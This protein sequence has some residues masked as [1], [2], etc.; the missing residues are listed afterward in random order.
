MS[1]NLSLSTGLFIPFTV[2]VIIDKIE[3]TSAILG[4]VFYICLRSFVFLGPSFTILFWI[5][6]IFSSAIF[7]FLWWVFQHIKKL[8]SVVS[9]GLTIY[10]SIYKYQLN[11][12]TKLILVKY[13]NFTLIM[14]QLLFLV[15]ILLLLHS[16]PSKNMSLNCVSQLIYRFFS[17][18][19][20]MVL[21]N[22]Q[23]LNPRMQNHIYRGRL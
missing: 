3:F 9:A 18:V 13:R 11:I 8:F 5:M 15:F 17:T 20:S 2:N 7:R 19:N 1:N 21:H 22:W 4:F 23:L 6:W 14:L 10:T 16:W 12:Y